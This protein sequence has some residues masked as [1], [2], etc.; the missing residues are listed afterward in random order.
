MLKT[1]KTNS[2]YLSWSNLYRV[3]ENMGTV[4]VQFSW[5]NGTYPVI[6][7]SQFSFFS[8][9]NFLVELVNL[10]F[11]TLI[12]LSVST[13][14]TTLMSI[15]KSLCQVLTPFMTSGLDPKGHN[16][17]AMEPVCGRSGCETGV[18]VWVWLLGS[19]SITSITWLVCCTTC[20]LYVQ[21]TT[22]EFGRYFCIVC[23]NT[24]QQTVMNLEDI[25]N[26]RHSTEM[27]TVSHRH[28]LHPRHGVS[29]NINTKQR[30]LLINASA[31]QQ[32]LAYQPSSTSQL[33]L[34]LT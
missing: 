24:R 9:H 19:N 4:L 29:S 30:V 25:F 16:L 7:S 20:L 34:S 28:A 26:K 2:S 10:I 31:Q 21:Q 22:M 14:S 12:I 27:Y 6:N 15:S 17:T 13:V 3:L 1:N 8:M 32:L 33:T 18:H 5:I 11:F 23:G